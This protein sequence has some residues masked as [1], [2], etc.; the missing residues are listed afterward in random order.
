L[1]AD[2]GNTP[3]LARAKPMPI[4]PIILSVGANAAQL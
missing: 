2:G 4:V 3:L 1:A